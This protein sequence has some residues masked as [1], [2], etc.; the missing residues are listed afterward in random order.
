MVLEKRGFYIHMEATFNVIH[1]I[2][3]ETVYIL[4]LKK[5]NLNKY[6]LHLLIYNVKYLLLQ[7]NHNDFTYHWKK[8]SHLFQQAEQIYFCFVFT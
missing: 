7:L 8:S 5:N 6:P 2:L 1:K 4:E 3:M